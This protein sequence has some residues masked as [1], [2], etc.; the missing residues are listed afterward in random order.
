MA[1]NQE[2]EP[3]ESVAAP[4]PVPSATR[5]AALRE[6]AQT[7]HDLAPKDVTRLC[8]LL[9]DV[10]AAL[11]AGAR[12]ADVHKCFCMHGSSISYP[13]FVEMLA[14]LRARHTPA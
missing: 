4:L 2:S 11:S 8:G 3:S 10:D 1:D 9:V 12:P 5:D 7:C 6:L 13:T 14:L